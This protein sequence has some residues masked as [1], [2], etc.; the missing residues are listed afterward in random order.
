MNNNRTL[1]TVNQITNNMKA[2]INISV[3]AVLFSLIYSTAVFGRTKV[4]DIDEANQLLAKTIN[5]GFTFDAPVEGAW[6]NSITND[7]LKSI[8]SAGF[9]AIRLPVQWITRMDS[10]APYTISKPFLDRIDEV[11]KQAVKN[12]LAIVIENCLDEQLMGAP[13]KYK[14]RFISLWEQLSAHFASYPQQV[15]FEIMAEPHGKLADIWN[16]YFPGALAVIRK[17]NATRPVIIGPVFYNNPHSISSLRLP[18]DDHYII[19]TFHLYEPLKFT[20]Q[21]EKWFPYGKPMEWIGTKWN[22]TTTE[23]KAIIDNMDII[24]KWAAINKRPVFMG[25]FGA[26]DHADMDSRARFLKFYREQAEQRHFSW[27]VWSYTVDY[28]IFDKKTKQWNKDL[29]NALVPR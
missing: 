29:L 13:D 6:G 24:S 25:E 5:M 14:A 20:M 11:T 2:R 26:S 22:A 21:G 8:R 16:D 9:T 7:E 18:E 10:I 28:S 3:L 23:Q 19:V 27:G 15:M 17:K 4:M 12:H 1:N